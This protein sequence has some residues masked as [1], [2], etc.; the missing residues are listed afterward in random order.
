M[1]PRFEIYKAVSQQ[2]R[3]IF[4]EH[5]PIIEPLSLG[6]YAQILTTDAYGLIIAVLP[7]RNDARVLRR[8]TRRRPGGFPLRLFS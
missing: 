5:T 6:D 2:I 8:E 3:E 7:P 1:K 4:A